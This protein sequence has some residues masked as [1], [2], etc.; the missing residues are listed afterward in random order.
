MP[1]VL[2]HV[3]Q[4]RVLDCTLHLRCVW[5]S[6]LLRIYERELLNHWDSAIPWFKMLPPQDFC[7]FSNIE[8]RHQVQSY[9]LPF[10][11]WC[12]TISR[13]SHR[14][15]LQPL[16]RRSFR[17]ILRRILP[18]PLYTLF[19]RSRLYLRGR[20]G[21]RSQERGHGWTVEP[22][23]GPAHDLVSGGVEPLSD[24]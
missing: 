2:D 14:F 17:L 11:C 15:W 19:L 5:I 1:T 4:I 9:Q 6:R 12:P 24:E 18:F 20:V 16:L 7:D 3:S 13:T 22:S 23:T 8:I 21:R 10:S